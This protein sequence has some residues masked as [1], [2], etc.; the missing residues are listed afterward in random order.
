[1][2]LADVFCAE[3][4]GGLEYMEFSATAMCM[5]YLAKLYNAV[6]RAGRYLTQEASVLRNIYSEYMNEKC[7]YIYTCTL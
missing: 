2:F 5:W 1:M 7:I 4:R 6:E 3:V